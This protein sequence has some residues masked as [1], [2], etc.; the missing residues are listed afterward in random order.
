MSETG[1]SKN[2]GIIRAVNIIDVLMQFM[3][4][5]TALMLVLTGFFG[6][7]DI[8]IGSCTAAVGVP[9]VMLYI[10]RG[11][12]KNRGLTIAAHA[13]AIVYAAMSAGDSVVRMAYIVIVL[14]L[15]VYSISIILGNKGHTSEH[16]PVG[17]G[18]IFVGAL[19]IG[20]ATD[21]AAISEWALYFGAAFILLQVVYRNLSN[22]N[23]IMTMNHNTGN[24]PARQMVKVDIFIMTMV[25]VLCAGAIVLADNM[26]VYKLLGALKQLIVYVLRFL[27]GLFRDDEQKNTVVIEPTEAQPDEGADFIPFQAESGVWQDVLNGI[28]VIVGVVVVIAVIAG[29]LAAAVRL[30]KRMRGGS[31]AGGDVREFVAPADEKSF[32]IRKRALRGEYADSVDMKARKIYKSMVRRSAAAKKEKVSCNMTP[33]ELSNAYITGMQ[34]E[35]T[36]IYEKARYSNEKVLP[37]EIELLK[38]SK[39]IQKS[40]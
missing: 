9:V 6:R 4:F 18:A 37:D 32:R 26:Y 2:T 34:D 28:A 11:W 25:G 22:L 21:R 20:E 36:D 40:I 33:K 38:K 14:V 5:D 1:V 19:I 8:G 35:I 16:V 31:R 39:K 27:F 3:I 12:C 13:A 23:G 30:M 7:T 24:F 15:T 29:I 10:V 17:V